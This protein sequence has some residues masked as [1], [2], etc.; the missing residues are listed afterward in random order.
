M[1]ICLIEKIDVIFQQTINL[2]GAGAGGSVCYTPMH[3][4]YIIG[5]L[6]LHNS[7]DVEKKTFI[8]AMLWFMK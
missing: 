7:D 4:F 8:V 3:L 2:M 5:M 1:L 6:E